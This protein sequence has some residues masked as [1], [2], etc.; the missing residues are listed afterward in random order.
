MLSSSKR[1]KRNRMLAAPIVITGMFTPACEGRI[2]R[3]PGPPQ[4]PRTPATA[5]TAP[6]D[7]T[8]IATSEPVASAAPSAS[9][10]TSPDVAPLS[11]IPTNAGGTVHR[12]SDGSCLYIYPELHMDCPPT[13][14][15]NP[16]PPLELK[17]KC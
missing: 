10:S 16:G 15:C 13:A 6:P 17:V 9:A 14:R 4:E 12:M 7:G 3:N 5:P 11:P 1:S 8:A 2:Y